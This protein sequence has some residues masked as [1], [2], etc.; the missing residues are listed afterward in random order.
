MKVPKSIRVAGF[1]YKIKVVDTD[2]LSGDYGQCRHDE[3]EM[4]LDNIKHHD[5]LMSHL[6]HEVIEAINNVYDLDLE[7]HKIE[8]LETALFQVLKDNDCF[9]K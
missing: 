6:L 2:G 1:D 8:L 9:N 5:S 3:K 7:H 4:V